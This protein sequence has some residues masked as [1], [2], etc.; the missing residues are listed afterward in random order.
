MLKNSN[1]TGVSEKSGFFK[2]V[3]AAVIL[4]ALAAAGAGY[5]LLNGKKS[6]VV[7][8][9]TT[10]EFDCN[11]VP[12]EMVRL[13]EGSFRRGDGR[14]I[15]LTRGFWMGK[16]EVTQAQYEAV[17]GVNP[18]HFRGRRRPVEQV[19]WSEAKIFCDKLNKIC[20][21]KLPAGYKFDLPTEAQWEYACRA[22]TATDFSYGDD[23]DTEK[24]NFDGNYPCGASRTGV[25][26]QQTVDV[27]SL[28]YKNAF[29]LYDMHGN[30]CE[31]CRDNYGQYTADAEDPAGPAS[32]LLRVFRGGSWYHFAKYCDSGFRNFW[33]PDFRYATLGFRVALVKL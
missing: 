2:L 10:C 24:M 18:S 14:V 26:R 15:S 32:G 31:W 16:F 23:S 12:L 8:E 29:G 17:T 28:G 13:P 11:G 5:H 4:A 30:V 7:S 33:K 20:A 22:G 6:A 25:Y 9:G 27:G 3:T 19:S 1:H 21:G